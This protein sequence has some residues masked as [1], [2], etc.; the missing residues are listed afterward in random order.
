[1]PTITISKIDLETLL[2]QKLSI[3]EIEALLPLVKGE[4]KEIKEDKL[5][6]ELADTNRPDLLS[7]EGI[8]RQ[9]NTKDK[10]D[11]SNIFKQKG[12]LEI[13]VDPELLK[14]RPYIGGFIVKGITLTEALLGA[15]IE[16]QEKLADGFGHKRKNI[17]IGIYNAEKLQFPIYYRAVLPTEKT[18]VPLGA[19]E[20][21]NLQEILDTHH[22]G[23]EYRYILEEVQP[24]E[25]QP[26]EV[27]PQEAN[28]FPFLEDSNGTPLSFPPIINSRATGEVKPGDNQLFCEVTGTDIEQLISIVNILAANFLDRG[29]VENPVGNP[30]GNPAAGGAAGGAASGTDIYPCTIKYP[31]PT[32]LGKTVITPYDFSFALDIKDEEFERVLGKKITTMEIRERLESYGY[33][34]DQQPKKLERSGNSAMAEHGPKNLIRVLVPS[35]RRDIMHPVDIIEDF[36]ISVGLEKFEPAPLEEFTM[37]KPASTQPIIDKIREIMIGC[38]FEETMSNIL[39]SENS[40]LTNLRLLNDINAPNELNDIKPVV[41]ENPI[42]DSYA[43]LRNSIIPS[44]LS[45]EAQSSKATYPHRIFEVGE[46][47]IQDSKAENKS[48]T[49]NRLAA[50]IAHPTSNFSELHSFL[51]TLM[52]Y[53]G[54]RYEFKKIVHPSFI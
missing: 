24:Q 31:Y 4:I 17:A 46:I 43:V 47:V 15:I 37:G 8:A 11:Y 33:K 22:K 26:Q 28:K 13:I 40:L 35:Y 5:I 53:L 38:G 9:I 1:M 25:V 41:I 51:D 39:T 30:V 10:R 23:K 7:V 2:S 6:L 21:L 49:K 16:T 20:E 32:Q 18:F 48:R 42:S 34:I 19:E 50:I 44:L 14:I 12:K 54:V 27:Q 52:Y 45:I 36:A 29:Q 3:I